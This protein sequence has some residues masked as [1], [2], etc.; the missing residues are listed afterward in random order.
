MQTR[1]WSQ[2][3]LTVISRKQRPGVQRVYRSG[4][5][6][7]EAG[8]TRC[9]WSREIEILREGGVSV[10]TSLVHDPFETQV[11]GT[12]GGVAGEHLRI[13]SVAVHVSEQLEVSRR[14]RARL[15]LQS[16]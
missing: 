10:L 4:R 11:N 3:R 16:Y 2:K 13:A 1:S 8:S 9:S 14:P 15:G 6:T 12:G 7:G 5:P